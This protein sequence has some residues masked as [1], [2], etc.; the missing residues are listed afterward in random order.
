MS[1]TMFRHEWTNRMK[2]KVLGWNQIL[3]CDQDPI[4][5]VDGP[6]YQLVGCIGSHTAI[7]PLKKP[8]AISLKKLP[9]ADIFFRLQHAFITVLTIHRTPWDD[10]LPGSARTIFGS[11]NLGRKPQVIVIGG[12]CE[13]NHGCIRMA[14]WNEQP[15]S[16]QLSP[17]LRVSLPH[18]HHGWCA[19][20]TSLQ[21][22]NPGK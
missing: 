2:L 11:A 22:A 19:L 5:E 21:P 4:R 16:Y 12:S 1:S 3:P 15:R 14:L 9:H 6:T 10:H 20:W 18:D 17:K 13:R 7:D 8:L